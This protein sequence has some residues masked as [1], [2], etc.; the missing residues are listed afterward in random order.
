MTP[1][2]NTHGDETVL[3][4]TRHFDAPREI[5]YRA[6]TDP[7]WL[8]RWIGPQECTCPHAETDLRVGGALKIDIRGPQG[9][10]NWAHGV[11]QTV[12]APARLTFTWQWVQEDGTLGQEMLIDLEFTESGE[13]TELVLTQTRFPTDESRDQHRGGWTG[14]FESLAQI[15]TDLIAES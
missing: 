3:R 9:I 6:W 11:Y 8:V 15:L 5:I 13:G 2:T 4:L 10:D 14:S 12:E 7:S 1:E